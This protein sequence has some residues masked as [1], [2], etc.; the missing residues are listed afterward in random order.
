[1]LSW[2]V[3]APRPPAF[4]DN[5]FAIPCPIFTVMRCRPWPSH[6]FVSSA[7]GAQRE[8]PSPPTSSFPSGRNAEHQGGKRGAG[9]G[10][11]VY[12]L[13]PCP[14]CLPEAWTSPKALP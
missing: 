4:S 2:N 8:T 10:L 12:D 3:F 9:G 11:V 7:V 5:E 14:L 6:F 1:M 13:V